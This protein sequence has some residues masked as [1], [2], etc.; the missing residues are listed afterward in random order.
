MAQM[1]LSSLTPEEHARFDGAAHQIIKGCAE[2]GRQAPNCLHLLMIYD[3]TLD[4]T[5]E[6]CG[7]LKTYH[8][9]FK[10]AGVLQCEER[11]LFLHCYEESKR[12]FVL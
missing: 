6:N 12:L 11:K 7:F 5:F 10:E 9:L 2:T 3:K 4:Y 1:V 8:K